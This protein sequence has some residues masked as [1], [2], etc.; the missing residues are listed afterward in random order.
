MKN[1]ICLILSFAVI[2]AANAQLR[3][4]SN[5]QGFNAAVQV[6][7]LG[8]SSEY[9]QYLDENAGS[10]V[11][12]GIR[13]GYGIT[14]LIEPYLGLD[15]TRLGV[16]NVDAK[17]FSMM[18]VDVGVRFNLA[19]TIHAFRPFLEGGYSFR[20]GKVN[21]V[22]NGM[23]YTDL[24]FSGGTPHLGGGINYFLKAPI[25]LFARGLFTVGK[26]SSVF[27]DDQKTADKSDVT[28]F[29]IGLGVNFNISELLQQQ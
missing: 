9:F 20:Q 5:T 28:T 18:H 12:G 11:G 21:E 26:S 15:V 8:W 16:S 27:L 2:L 10:G 25:S 4:R 3:Q 17:S 19:G 23:V 14:Q 22:I 29:R 13:L 7:A 1:C 6:H 24:K